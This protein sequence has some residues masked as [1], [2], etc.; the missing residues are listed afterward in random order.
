MW[1]MA[2]RMW[3]SHPV[4]L[5]AAIGASIGLFNAVIL[6]I[7]GPH[8][9]LSTGLLLALWPT[10]ILGFGYNGTSFMYSTFLGIVEVGGNAVLYGCVLASP[11]GFV[12]VIRRSFSKQEKP[13]SIGRI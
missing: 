5:S 1:K 6:I 2:I 10:S 9:M 12:V 4:L 7:T 13:T 8:T 11:V 3:R